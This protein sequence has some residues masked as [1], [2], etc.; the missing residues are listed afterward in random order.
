MGN[1]VVYVYDN[2]RAVSGIKLK[3]P[4]VSWVRGRLHCRGEGANTFFFFKICR[5]AFPRP[6]YRECWV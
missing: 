3:H 5:F 4:T 1:V 6:V 2:K